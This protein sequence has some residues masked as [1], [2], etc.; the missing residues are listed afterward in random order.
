M[1]Y[2]KHIF[3]TVVFL[4]IVFFIILTLCIFTPLA[5]D[6]WNYVFI[7]G[8]DVRIS[9]LVDVLKSQYTHYFEL[10]GR[11][12]SHILV[13]IVD[14][15]WGKDVFNVINPLMFVVFLYAIT[16]NVTQD[17]KQYYKTLTAA[18]FLIFLIFPGFNMGV[19]WLSGAFNYLWPATALLFFHF[20]MEKKQISKKYFVPLF[21]FA[22]ICGWS[23][24]AFVVGL[25]GAYL[26]YYTCK[27]NELTAQRVVMLVGFFIG[28]LFLVLSPGSII[29]AFGTGNGHTFYSTFSFFYLFFNNFL[30]MSN[31]RI[32]PLLIIIVAISCTRH[33]SIKRWI[34]QETI[35]LIAMVISFVFVLA[36]GY[37]S[38][39]SRWGIELFALL[40]VLRL[41]QW[42]KLDSRFFHLVNVVVGVCAIF[43]INASYKC[44]V[45]N[46]EEFA[47]MT[48][49]E[50]PVQTSIADYHPLLG[51]FI[52]PYKYTGWGTHNKQFG[53]DEFLSKY[54]NF[55][56]LFLIPRNF[57]QAITI[58]PERF[59]TF[60][61]DD[62]WPFYA[63]KVSKES[64]SV[65]FDAKIEMTPINYHQYGWPLKKI[66]PYIRKYTNN[67]FTIETMKFT[68]DS[69]CYVLVWKN[70]TYTDRIKDI[71][72]KEINQ[73]N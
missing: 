55:D 68:T 31:L 62:T 47:Q 71:T 22:L 1:F 21:L 8:T 37:T 26:I 53:E 10:N 11:T 19:L 46:N 3:I 27:R 56:H 18:F 67:S 64:E 60:Q 59:N 45:L 14:S 65:T 12:P 33:L 63:I 30:G 61:T 24:E 7:V 23:N 9:S 38:E 5:T 43:A 66:L 73:H 29:K 42:D 44:F 2:S 4:V 41:P 6:D 15:F 20:I 28:A 39:H 25:A 34:R 51:R 40:L 72:L 50:Y 58:H 16:V 69:T 48:R 70:E 13:Q 17:F 49:H 32:M 57:I 35:L 54:F 36:T 52:V